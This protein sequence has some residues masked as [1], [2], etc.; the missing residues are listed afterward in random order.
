MDK[1]TYLAELAEG[2]ARWVPERERQDILRYYAEYFEEAGPGREAE[3]VQELGDPWALSCRL[4]VEGGFVSQQQAESWTPPRRKK[5]PWL[6][7]AGVTAAVLLFT[8]VSVAIGAATFG[9]IVGRNV[10]GLVGQVAVAKDPA[11]TGEVTFFE[12][13]GGSTPDQVAAVEDVQ[14]WAGTAEGAPGGFWTREDGLLDTFE[15]IDV[16]ISFGNVTVTEGIDYTLDIQPEGDLGGYALK[17]AVKDGTLTVQDA[18]PGG[19]RINFDGLFGEH[20][21]NVNITVPGEVME[22]VS[23]KTNLGDVFLSEVRA[24]TRIEARTALGNVEC[25]EVRAPQ[26]LT[27][28]SDL[29][30]VTLGMGEF[31]EGMDIDLKT[32]LGDVEANMNCYERECEYDLRCDLGKV[33]INGVERGGKAEQKGSYS[34]KLDAESDLGNVDIYFVD[35]RW[36]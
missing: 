6:A 25:Y 2:L 8:V 15:S 35:S 20:S 13:D 22:K 26:K 23:V 19:A 3:V 24:E 7:A 1:I 31:W 14:V 34:C 36:Q 5:W 10:A 12:Y 21:L 16:D 30:D 28:K 17:W 9:K 32:N 18:R 4:A 27:L 29:G 11:A 33:T